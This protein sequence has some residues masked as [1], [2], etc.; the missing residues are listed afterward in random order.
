MTT[1][2]NENRGSVA[3]LHEMEYIQAE[4]VEYRSGATL[5]APAPT[6]QPAPS[7]EWHSEP[8]G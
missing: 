5:V 7:R 1:G 3:R 6:T 4:V 2:K 8:V